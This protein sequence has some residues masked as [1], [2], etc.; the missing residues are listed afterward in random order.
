VT[1]DA[2][3]PD[4]WYGPADPADER[5][6]ADGPAYPVP[7]EPDWEIIETVTEYETPWYTGGYDSV[8]QPDGSEK[9]YYWAE[10]APATVVV[11]VAGDEVVMV[12]QYRPPIRETHLE[13][14]AGIVEPG[15][16]YAE[17]GLRELREETGYA[18][19][20]ATVLAAYWTATGVLRH[21]RGIV[22]ADGLT[23]TDAGPER[24][25][26][27]FLTVHTVPVEDVLA[28]ARDPPASDA[29]LEGLLLAS[30]DGLL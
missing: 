14:P 22:F 23:P 17:A 5:R 19:D 20:D 26:N 6:P 29:T 3:G 2:D 15:E 25:T 28:V 4:G 13:L 7:D 21:R 9:R 27:E 12:E 11:G 8:E 16:G 30:E 18:A 24:D 10:L 1:N